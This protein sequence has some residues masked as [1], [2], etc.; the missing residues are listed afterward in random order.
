[1]ISKL[2]LLKKLYMTNGSPLW[3]FEEELILEVANLKKEEDLVT[4]EGWEIRPF[5]LHLD[6][7]IGARLVMKKWPLFI[8]E[9]FL[10]L[11]FGFFGL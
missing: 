6:F 1:M 11:H 5:N 9:L 4:P 7:L 10:W 3:A 2:L 8:I